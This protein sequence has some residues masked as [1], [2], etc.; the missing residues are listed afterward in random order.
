MAMCSIWSR[1]CCSRKIPKIRTLSPNV[2]ISSHP[3]LP[4]CKTFLLNGSLALKILMDKHMILLEPFRAPFVNNA[5][6]FVQ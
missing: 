3:E 4:F 5:Q 6:S 1:T 2:V